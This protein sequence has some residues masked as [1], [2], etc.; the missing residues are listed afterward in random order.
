MMAYTLRFFDYFLPDSMCTNPSD[1]MRGYI[2]VGL[3]F[4]NIIIALLTMLGLAF[5]LE[6]EHNTPIA[7]ALDGA[8]LVGYVLTLYLLTRTANY[9]LCS[10]LLVGIIASVIFFGVQITG[11]YLESPI[12][13]LA[14]QIPVMGFLLLGLHM[15]LVWLGITLA[16]CLASY[17]SG[18]YHIGSVQLLQN[19]QV[20]QAMYILLQFVL[21]ILV[22]AGLSVYET[23][24]SLLKKE[25]HAEKLKL[26]HWAS[27]D[28][29]TG[30][31]NRFEFFRRLKAGIDEAQEREHKVGVVYIDLD[32]FK[33][34]N[35]SH[36]HHMGDAALKAVAERLQK[37]LRLSDTTARLGGDEFGLILPGIHVPDDIEAIMPK[38]LEAIR[39]PIQVGDVKISV[40]GSCGVAI[41]PNHSQDCDD[42]CRYADAAMYRAKEISDSYMIYGNPAPGTP[43]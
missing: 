34:V 42:L 16:L 1:L 27:H 40:R 26:E 37:V 23:L 10:N 4:T 7:L 24:N 17:Y 21:V 32:G 5:I 19:E 28:D 18:V 22:G 33:P 35:D 43:A 6:L 15:G 25:L 41:F 11:G 39:E 2:L 8:C 38:I 9:T 30:I 14:L 36:G 13:Q 31:A 29:L 12:L 3:I 20:T